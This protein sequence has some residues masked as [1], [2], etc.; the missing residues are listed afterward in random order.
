MDSFRTR[1]QQEIATVGAAT[2]EPRDEEISWLP[3]LGEHLKCFR[4]PKVRRAAQAMQ[5]GFSMDRQRSIQGPFLTVH[6]ILFAMKYN[7][8]ILDRVFSPS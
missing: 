7:I 3:D 6:K 1:W 8:Y 5:I 2:A 4:H